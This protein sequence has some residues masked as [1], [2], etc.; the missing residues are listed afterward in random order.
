[1][2]GALFQTGTLTVAF[3]IVLSWLLTGLATWYAGRSG[4]VDQPGSRH[5]HR[6]ATPRGGGAGMIAAFLAASLGFAAW[7][8]PPEWRICAAPG[9]VAV[10]LL[11][12]WDDH[13]EPSPIFKITKKGGSTPD[14]VAE[15]VDYDEN[16]NEVGRIPFITD[17]PPAAAR[18]QTDHDHAVV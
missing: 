18:I 8:A 13:C 11:G 5:S 12:W 2:S 15:L 14:G 16:G 17:V 10:A 3:T 9:L 6:R 4:L 1:M 7:A